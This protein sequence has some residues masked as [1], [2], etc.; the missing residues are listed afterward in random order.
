MVAVLR[1]AGAIGVVVGLLLGLAAIVATP[2]PAGAEIS[3]V[4][5]SSRDVNPGG[6]T[7][8]AVTVS[9]DGITCISAI[10]SS[11]ELDPKLS[12]QCTPAD[13]DPRR[14]S[15]ILRVDVPTEPGTYTV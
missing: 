2:L 9:A 4:S 11:S 15:S 7:S 12:P 5:P 8:A 6:S 1:R 13:A 14:W 3:S 10:P